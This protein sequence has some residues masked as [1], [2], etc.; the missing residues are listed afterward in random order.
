MCSNN[1]SGV[2]PKIQRGSTPELSPDFYKNLCDAAHP[3]HARLTDE[4]D[5][6]IANIKGLLEFVQEIANELPAR[7]LAQIP[8]SAIIGFSEIILRQV[9]AVQ[10][11][12]EELVT[13]RFQLEKTLTQ[14]Q[15]ELEESQSL[16]AHYQQE[17]KNLHQ[18]I[19]KNKEVEA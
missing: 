7:D 14:T 15:K 13:Q 11:M 18:A 2:S 12:H 10:V 8:E 6:S 16:T 19:K 4:I 9:S 17:I 5:C 3:F 1:Q